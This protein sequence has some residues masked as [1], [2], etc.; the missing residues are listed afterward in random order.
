MAY[1]DPGMANAAVPWLFNPQGQMVI[2]DPAAMM[3]FGQPVPSPGAPNPY[4][5]MQFTQPPGAQPLPPPKATNMD[6]M[7]QQPEPAPEI[8]GPPESLKGGGEGGGPGGGKDKKAAAYGMTAQQAQAL[9][10]LMNPQASGAA[11]RAAA[12][13]A[14]ALPRGLQGNMQQYQMGQ[15]GARPTLSTLL[16]QYRA[17]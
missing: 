11:Q 16:N 4:T 8:A 1:N 17:R 15:V 3:S 6:Y 2:N 12:A 10:Q 13:P 9:S 5:Q 7:T 14:A